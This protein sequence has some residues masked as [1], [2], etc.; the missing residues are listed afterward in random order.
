MVVFAAYPHPKFRVLS[1]A[2]RPQ[3]TVEPNG[4]AM[5]QIIHNIRHISILARVGGL[6]VIAIVALVCVLAVNFW[7][8]ENRSF[9]EGMAVKYSDLLSNARFVELQGLQLRQHEK[10]FLLEKDVQFRTAYVRTADAIANQIS[11]LYDDLSGEGRS[12][13]VRLQQVLQRHRGQFNIV[14]NLQEEVGLNEESGLQGALREAVHTI[15]EALKNHSNKDLSILMLM[16][17]R[18]EKDFIARLDPKYITRIATRDQ[19]FRTALD[20]AA[21]PDEVKALI[22]EKLGLYVQAFN[23]YAAKRQELIREITELETIYE[24]TLEGY[25][26]IRDFA[27]AGYA[28]AQADAAR[29]TETA[30]ILTWG[31]SIV[32]ILAAGLGSAIVV[33]TTVGPVRRLQAAVSQIADGQ[34]DTHVPGTEYRDELGGVAQAIETLRDNASER[35]RLEQEA[36][37]FQ[38]REARREREESE[39]KVAQERARF[40]EEAHLAQEREERADALRRLVAGFEEQISKNM[41]R[42]SDAS[43]DMQESAQ[44]MFDVAEKTGTSATSVT[45]AAS[46]MD[47]SVSV[48]STAIEEFS[49]SIAEVNAQVRSANTL[50]DN[51]VSATSEGTDSITSLAESAKQVDEVM[52]LIEDIAAQTNLLAL[53]ATIEAA[54]AGEAGKGFAVVASEVKSLANQTASAT[55]RVG[56]QIKGM[57]TSVEIVV[58]AMQNVKDIIDQLN[59]IMTGIASASEEQEST[60]SE[61]R[62]NVSVSTESARQVSAEISDVNSNVSKTRKVSGSVRTA[63]DDLSR[64][65][66]T[67]SRDTSEFLQQVRTM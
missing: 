26:G 17:R 46:A 33:S 56:T 22:R 47:D 11:A 61:I 37:E 23:N 14:A 41:L 29:T 54:R 53:N 67:M 6:A 13:A 31:I 65:G 39:N 5:K 16:M 40:E 42:L 55:D 7:T 18:H 57:Q 52:Q 38:A 25:E 32:A 21:F 51:A 62:R 8:T 35:L 48:M 50:C 27:S 45:N 60:T 59:S 43:Y 66:E 1:A 63:A 3:L 24:Q 28:R 20:N 9:A 44:T 15:E 64:L 30:S 49:A 12:A 36:K 4:L 19:E 2:Y 34:F 58:G 10:N